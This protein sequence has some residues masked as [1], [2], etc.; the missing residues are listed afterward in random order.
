M[1]KFK[2]FISVIF[3][4]FLLIGTSAIKNETRE[5]EKKIDVLKKAYAQKERNF[6]EVQLDYYYLTSPSMIEKKIEHLG[7]KKYIH[8]EYSKIFLSIENFINVQNNHVMHKI[9]DE[10]KVQKK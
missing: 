10:K 8:M 4:S 3:V 9:S 2:I 7:V 1:S 5:L 6:N